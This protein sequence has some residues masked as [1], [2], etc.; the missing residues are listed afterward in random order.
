MRYVILVLLNLPVILFA[1]MNL[2]MRYKLGKISGQR[3][4]IQFL[5]WLILLIVL[6]GSFPV[7]NHFSGKLIL[8]ASGLTMFDIVQTTAI[9]LLLY[10]VNSQRQRIDWTERTLRDLHQELS[11]KLSRDHGKISKR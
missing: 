3:F 5:L 8:D 10:I 1:F 6:I 2:V 9:I 4:R 11:I 7:Y